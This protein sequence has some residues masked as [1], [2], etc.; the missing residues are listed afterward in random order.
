M[1]RQPISVNDDTNFKLRCKYEQKA[2]DEWS[3]KWDWILAQNKY[4]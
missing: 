3:K 4:L 1:N 2:F